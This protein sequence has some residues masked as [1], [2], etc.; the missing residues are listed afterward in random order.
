MSYPHTTRI[1]DTKQ[2]GFTQ[3]DL[4]MEGRYGTNT[5]SP[6]HP[7]VTR[8]KEKGR[9]VKNDETGLDTEENIETTNLG[10][11]GDRGGGGNV[12]SSNN[13]FS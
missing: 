8:D 12:E 7:N 6:S 10:D 5:F 3:E 11:S 9:M 4:D 2:G 1:S 13:S